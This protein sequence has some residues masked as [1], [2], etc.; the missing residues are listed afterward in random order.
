MKKMKNSH[1]CSFCDCMEKL[2][3]ENYTLPDTAEYIY[4]GSY[5]CDRYFLNTPEETW[6]VCLYHINNMSRK[7]V[8]VIPIPGQN[9]LK[10][11]LDKVEKLVDTGNISELVVNDPGMLRW[12]GKMFP[13]MDIWSGRLMSKEIRDPRYNME[14][15]IPDRYELCRD[16]T[17]YGITV[18][19]VESDPVFPLRVKLS[20]HCQLGVHTPYAFISASRYCEI[21]SI[22]QSLAKKFRLDTKCGRQCID[23]GLIYKNR[24]ITFY[25]SGR[26]VLTDSQAS[27][28]ENKGNIRI[29]HSH[30]FDWSRD[31]ITDSS[32]QH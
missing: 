25:K 15:Q 20:D 24:G 16:G 22:G 8:L 26:A 32:E 11:I 2:I 31:E 4:I 9:L 29:I 21:G 28:Y 5:F 7:A 6:R 18:K 23:C 1:A 19:G 17:L 10:N 13:E 3:C 14:F 12:C 27:G 30:K